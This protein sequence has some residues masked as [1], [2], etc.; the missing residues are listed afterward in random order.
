MGGKVGEREGW[1]SKCE[2]VPRKEHQHSR[3]Q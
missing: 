2:L 3:C 1:V